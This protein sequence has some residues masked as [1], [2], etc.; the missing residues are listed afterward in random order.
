MNVHDLEDFS[1][2]ALKSQALTILLLATYGEGDPTDNAMA[3]AKWLKDADK[4]IPDAFLQGMKYMV[5]ALGDTQY[6]H[7]N[8]MGKLA[9]K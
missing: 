9:D 4:E 5:F 7:F 3:F 8:A 2:E 6:E 1:P